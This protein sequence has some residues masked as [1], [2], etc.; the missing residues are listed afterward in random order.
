MV[1]SRLNEHMDR[2]NLHTPQQ[3]GYKKGHST[4]HVVLEIV[5]EVLVGFDRPTATLVTLLDLS[6]AF[7]TVDLAKL[8]YTLESK[9]WLNLF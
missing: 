1:L 7:D 5:D 4:E 3:F 9:D 2:N 6:A 8:M